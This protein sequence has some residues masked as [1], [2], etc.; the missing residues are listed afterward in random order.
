[1]QELLAH[2]SHTLLQEEE[3]QQM[4]IAKD[5]MVTLVL[6]THQLSRDICLYHYY[7]YFYGQLHIYT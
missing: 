5:A 6:I 3:S 2:H 1:L 4:L 7:K